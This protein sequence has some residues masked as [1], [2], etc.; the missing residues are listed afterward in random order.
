MPVSDVDRPFGRGRRREVAGRPWP[1]VEFPLRCHLAE[2][3]VGLTVEIRVSGQKY[4]SL[5]DERSDLL[6][7]TAG[8]PQRHRDRHHRRCGHRYFRRSNFGRRRRHSRDAVQPSVPLPDPRYHYGFSPLRQ[9][10]PGP[11][12]VVAPALIHGQRITIR[13]A[14]PLRHHNT[15][16]GSKYS[17]SIC[18][19][20][21]GSRPSDSPR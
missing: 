2:T 14:P 7:C 9:P 21:T 15:R 20:E 12:F 6:G 19:F 16:R 5:V 10:D 17:A 3:V 11:K 8:L 13:P 18:R 4:K 1:G